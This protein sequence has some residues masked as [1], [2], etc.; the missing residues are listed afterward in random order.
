MSRDTSVPLPLLLLPPPLPPPSRDVFMAAIAGTAVTKPTAW[1]ACRTWVHMLG[2]LIS[3]D[4]CVSLTRN[5]LKFVLGL[6][7]LILGR[8]PCA[9]HTRDFTEVVVCDQ[10][11]EEHASF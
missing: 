7:P 4:H 2:R 6:T 3:P 11:F 1:K 10:V 5:S 9:N 8:E